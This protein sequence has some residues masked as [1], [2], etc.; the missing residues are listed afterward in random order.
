MGRA[1]RNVRLCRR[2]VRNGSLKRVATDFAFPKMTHRA[3]SDVLRPLGHQQLLAALG[4]LVHGVRCP[5]KHSSSPSVAAR[6]F[7]QRCGG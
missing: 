5:K 6:F 7:A 1:M 2:R 3:L 4:A